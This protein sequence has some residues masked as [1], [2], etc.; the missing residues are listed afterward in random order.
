MTPK[1]SHDCDK[2]T[3]LGDYNEMDLYHC[4]Q[5]GVYATVIARFG[6]EGPDYSSG[7]PVAHLIPEL[8]EARRRAEEQ[9]LL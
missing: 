1:F 3:Y 7:L 5:G 4:D 2:C 8:A 9:G 6:N